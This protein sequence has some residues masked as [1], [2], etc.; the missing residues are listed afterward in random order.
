[1]YSGT[2]YFTALLKRRQCRLMKYFSPNN[3]ITIL[4]KTTFILRL[5]A[6]IS[7]WRHWLGQQQKT[8]HMDWSQRHSANKQLQLRLKI[9]TVLLQFKKKKMASC[10]D[11]GIC[12]HSILTPWGARESDARTNAHV[13]FTVHGAITLTY[14][15][16]TESTI[17]PTPSHSYKLPKSVQQEYG[18]TL[19]DTTCD[20]SNTRTIGNRTHVREP[21]DMLQ[22]DQLR[23]TARPWHSRYQHL[24]GRGTP[25][26]AHRN[27]GKWYG[28]STAVQ[29][30]SDEQCV[31]A[32]MA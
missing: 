25:R 4:A 20:S 8:K 27:T 18:R 12:Q 19:T 30:I 7:P 32:H 21:T 3:C 1:M 14:D 2:E 15:T 17:K 5:F 24:E 6:R 28:K 26:H 22:T 31:I 13:I 11:F 29:N 9:T 23:R 10:C 16:D